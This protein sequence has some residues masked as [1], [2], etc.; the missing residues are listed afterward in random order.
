MGG[1]RGTSHQVLRP[2]VWTAQVQDIRRGAGQE[3]SSAGPS[4]G[5]LYVP[6]HRPLRYQRP[7]NKS[8]VRGQLPREARSASLT[9]VIQTRE[10]VNTYVKQGEDILL[11]I[12]LGRN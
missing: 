4:S 1:L 10:P 7:A 3:S 9:G 11:C 5:S 6:P 12:S 8:G 2:G